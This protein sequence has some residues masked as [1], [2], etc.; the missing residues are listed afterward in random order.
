VFTELLARVGARGNMVQDVYLAAMAIENGGDF[1]S[2]DRGCGRLPGLRRR[3]PL[4]P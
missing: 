2:T 1:V 3:H 4:E